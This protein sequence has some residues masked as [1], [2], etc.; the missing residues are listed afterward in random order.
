[1]DARGRWLTLDGKVWGAS[2]DESRVRWIANF[3]MSQEHL[4]ATVDRLRGLPP[5]PQEEL[6]QA[7]ARVFRVSLADVA[8]L[9]GLD[10]G[11][12]A[13][14]DTIGEELLTARARPIER[15]QH[16]AL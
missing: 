15:S 13:K 6:T 3:L 5:P 7:E 11:P 1:M 14:A 10:F 16:V 9:T 2:M 12:L 4:L 8:K